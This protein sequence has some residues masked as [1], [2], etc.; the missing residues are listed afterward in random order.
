MSALNSAMC[1]WRSTAD[2]RTSR[3]GRSVILFYFFNNARSGIDLDDIVVLEYQRC[4]V[5]FDFHILILHHLL[6]AYGLRPIARYYTPGASF[7]SLNSL[8]RNELVNFFGADVI[9][10]LAFGR[11]SLRSCRSSGTRS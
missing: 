7:G 4:F 10:T 5:P 1:P 11:Y 3:P 9:H 2:S 8:I 6:T